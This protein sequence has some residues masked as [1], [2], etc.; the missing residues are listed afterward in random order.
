MDIAPTM[1]REYYIVIAARCGLLIV[2]HS[3]Y[4]GTSLAML[5]PPVA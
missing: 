3:A 5:Y 4:M 1:M 2:K